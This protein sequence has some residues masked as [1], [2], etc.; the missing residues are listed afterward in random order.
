MLG[1]PLASRYEPSDSVTEDKYGR[2]TTGRRTQDGRPVVLSVLDPGLKAG[3]PEVVAVAETS[4]RLAEARLSSILHCLEAGRTDAG[5]LYLVFEA[6]GYDSL[7]ALLRARNSLP[8][9]AALAVAWRIASVL[10][11]ASDRG[12]HHLDLTSSNVFVDPETLYVRVA[13][14]GFSRLLPGYAPARRN[15]PFHG[16][17]E[18]LAPEVCAGRAGDAS[19][20]LY[21]LGILMY[22]MVAGKPPFVSSSPSTTIKRQV[23]E[24]PL[25]LRVARPGIPGIEGYERVLSRLLAKD[26]RGRP[27]DAAEALA[28]LE[29]LRTSQFPGADLTQEPPREAPIEVECLLEADV[30]QEP[31]PEPEAREP[32]SRETR[33]FTGL[34]AEV[35][36]AAGAVAP[37]P[38]AS[39]AQRAV[40]VS[41]PTEAFDSSLVE[42]ALREEAA[43]RA[44]APSATTEEPAAATPA[45]T[46]PPEGDALESARKAAEWFVEGSEALPESVFPPEEEERKESR[47]FWVIVGAVAI[48]L[49]VGAVVYFEGAKPPPAEPPPP[50]VV[51][52]TR[53]VPPPPRPPVPP[54]AIPD[55]GPAVAAVPDPGPP[56]EPP[57][58]PPPPE[59]S[60]EE[61]K[62]RQVADLLAAGRQA[63]EAGNLDEARKAVESALE[64]DRRNPDGKALLADIRKALRATDRRRPRPPAPPRPAPDDLK[65]KRTPPAAPP[66]PPDEEAQ[67]KIKQHIRAGR[68]AYNQGDYQKAI[69]AY[70]QALQLDPDNALVKKLL[71]QA[72]AKANP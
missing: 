45:V 53:P 47:M 6:A 28:E 12:V 9:E 54:A 52:P 24:K 27:A 39:P 1:E 42:A 48:L 60:P 69:Q 43:G 38:A 26:P 5:N 36:R 20:D 16:T 29:A 21:A 4:R 68:N 18:Y 23:Y 72:R 11:A 19:A 50:V 33:V 14:Y 55:P 49:I 58:P 10:K 15:E 31:A 46:G 57:P 70:N 8:I 64:L 63:F 34:A 25:P 56:P 71:D 37:P 51:A 40:E 13:R 66:A 65:L 62:A 22:E 41:R 2:H 30:K 61:A 44:E 35:A 32:E 59:P 3:V 17:A 7:K 67:A